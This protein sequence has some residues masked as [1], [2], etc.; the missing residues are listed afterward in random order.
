MNRDFTPAWVPSTFWALEI[1]A[2]IL[3]LRFVQ[4]I[5]RFREVREFA[6]AGWQNL[7]LTAVGCIIPGQIIT[8][9]MHRAA[10]AARAA[11]SSG[12]FDEICLELGR[13]AWTLRGPRHAKPCRDNVK[14]KEVH[15]DMPSKKNLPQFVKV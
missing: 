1:L 14:T 5:P 8:P 4:G 2:Q 9:R 7:A 3:A 10:C 11:F 13:V 12:G 15:E 6:R